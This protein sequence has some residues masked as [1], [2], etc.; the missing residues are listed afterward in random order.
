[1]FARPRLI[2]LLVVLFVGLS[3]QSRASDALE[4]LRHIAGE[5]DRGSGT[6]GA[7]RTADYV[8][9]VFANLPPSAG[10]VVGRHSFDLPVRQ[11]GQARLQA[12]GR[13]APLFPLFANSLAPETTPPEGLR[14]PLFYGGGGTLAELQGLSLGGAIVV[15]DLDSGSNWLHA[16]RLGVKAAIY[17][18]GG[19]HAAPRAVFRDKEELTPLDFPR[20]WLP[21]GEFE[22][23]F[24]APAAM[25]GTIAELHGQ[26]LWKKMVVENVFCF[27]PG[28]NTTYSGELL[29][30]EAFLDV[31][32]Y[33]P[34]HAPG[35]DQAVSLATMLSVAEQF[36]AERPQRPVLFLASSGHGNNLAGLRQALH[37]LVGD[38]E[39]VEKELNRRRQELKA[40]VVVGEA[41]GQGW[42]GG[43]AHSDS[44]PVHTALRDE[45][46]NEI[47]RLN[48]QLRTARRVQ[49]TDSVEIRRLAE[50][51]LIL[52]RLSWEHDYHALGAEDRRVVEGFV[53]RA[54]AR[55]Q[56]LRGDLEDRI[57]ALESGAALRRLV[58]KKRIVAA[59]SL[60]LSS[61]GGGVAAVEAG[62]LYQPTPTVNRARNY[63]HLRPLLKE[64]AKGE[65]AAFLDLLAGAGRTEWHNY[66]PDKP[67][68]GGQLTALA[69]LPGLTLA[70]VNDLRSTWSTPYDTLERV[71]GEG[72]TAQAG[73]I[74]AQLRALSSS[75]LP[76][77]SAKMVNGFAV[78]SGRANFLRQGEIFAEQVAEQVLLQI[79][80]DHGYSVVWVDSLGQFSLPGLA[81]QKHSYGKAIIEGYRFLPGEN[82]ASWAI[83]KAVTD[84]N[85]YRVKLNRGHS[86]TDLVMFGCVQTTLFG[87]REARSLNPLT[88][89]RLLDSRTETEPSHYWYSR[90]DTRQ[91]SLA[92]LF[93]EADTP[94]KLTLSDTILERK[95]MLLNNGQGEPEGRG[96]MASA[97]PAV[98][99]TSLQAAGDM[100]RLTTPRVDTLR[101][102]SIVNQR[103]DG[104]L[105][106]AQEELSL[107]EKA[108]AELRH[109]AAAHHTGNSLAAIVRVYNDVEKTQRDVL[110]GVLFFIAL[111]IPF[112][113]CMERLL[114][115]HVAIHKRLIS[116]SGLLLAIIA[117]IAAVHPA[118]K[119]TYSP[120][121]VILAFFILGLSAVVTMI[122]GGRF[123]REMQNLQHRVH[124]A[125][126]RGIS[127]WSAFAAAFAIGVTNLRRRKV[128]T[129]LTTATLAILTYTLLNFTS[130]KNSLEHGAVRYGETA[131]YQ[132]VLL[133][134]PEWKNLPAELA[135]ELTAAL[136][137]EGRWLRR[138]WAEGADRTRAPIVVLGAGGKEAVASGLVGLD[139]GEAPLLGLDKT[140]ISG[141]WLGE[142]AGNEILLSST[143]AEQLGITSLTPRPEVILWGLIFT[144][145]GIFDGKAYDRIIDL[146]G[147]PLTSVVYPNEVSST[148]SEAEA[149][150]A[151]SGEEISK[152]AGRYQ[153][154]EGERIAIIPAHLLL[155]LGG[156]LKSLALATSGGATR[157]LATRLADRYQ[158]LLFHG[159]EEGVRLH[160][161]V[162][163]LSY[164]GMGNV[165]IPFVI[166]ILILLNTMVG[167]VVER[168]REIAVYTSVGLAPPHVASLFVAE[169]LAFGII[170]A[171]IGYL[172]AQTAAHF[173]AGTALWAG[174]TANY[175]SLAG[176]ASLIIV[177]AVVLLSV[178]YP[179]R[180]A[181][182][183]AIPDV[184]RTFRLPAVHG[185]S[186]TMPLPFLFKVPEQD[187][188]V[189]F[190]LEYYQA[191]VDVAHG[192]FAVED[193][194]VEYACP[195]GR[196][197]AAHADCFTL[198]FCAWLAPFDF[199]IRQR[200]SIISCPSPDY[201]GFLEMNLTVVRQSGEK[202]VWY[203]LCREFVN[204]LR[205][206]LLIWRS[207]EREEKER[208]EPVAQTRILQMSEVAR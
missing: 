171:V 80:Q 17:L 26:S 35:A 82:R 198:S 172:A 201:P 185:A 53:A 108:A 110:G 16:A 151:E 134:A 83:D 180:V 133:K 46:R 43:E 166:A 76:A 23:V 195:V 32:R 186:M 138:V 30:V 47:E 190:L 132:G 168:R 36:A 130:V 8:Y 60:H 15:L 115:A 70:T 69:G 49:T 54:L 194:S 11:A 109:E 45:L 33:V 4:H 74:G 1:M 146:D 51:K 156:G 104:L 177:M 116:F 19:D 7:A 152:M 142:G 59:V 10:A 174:M 66:F 42:L 52:R 64:A 165:V 113:Y 61:H 18:D 118:F 114:F 12:A 48:L 175:S 187:C 148:L 14:G 77:P 136:P 140:L 137:G 58:D 93:L 122:L 169:A 120:L 75:E 200:V 67:A 202:N 163:S 106:T 56:R 124:V 144:V 39:E 72:V 183:I 155:S 91:S 131:P 73:L 159:S 88:R 79:Y 9:S 191:H 176:V 24:A 160:Y 85:R 162:G 31:G 55:N 129:A 41:L 112:A 149:E 98:F 40:A 90:I 153:H 173:L 21:R 188:I 20:Y 101:R 208:F 103:I 135:G 207:L 128:R 38:R 13:V 167:S 147:E 95:L 161:S 78:L 189:G 119:L 199:A 65:N 57:G 181:G 196:A 99:N 92:S 127:F 117:I 111:F 63:T 94:F 86:K 125:K 34:G 182:R 97:T 84:K 107:A 204:D 206:Q 158:L 197:P 102:H 25:N 139:P 157:E 27:L 96:F 62:Y 203:R 81:D 87:L 193:I 50:E 37:Y 3:G 68:L 28:T 179:A 150:A 205:R 89:L 192:L 123:E 154:I 126:G 121:V 100:V 141:Q 145:Q 2:I 184:T 5:A 164:A 143:L 170:S 44:E 29:L 178:I 22:R 105:A 71:D 6:L